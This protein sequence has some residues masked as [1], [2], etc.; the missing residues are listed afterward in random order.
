ML[1]SFAGAWWI[2]CAADG[3][4]RELR[5]GSWPRLGLIPAVVLIEAPGRL[6]LTLKNPA[7]DE[8]QFG[9]TLFLINKG[10]HRAMLVVCAIVVLQVLW[11]IGLLS[12]QSYRKR[13]AAQH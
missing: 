8:A 3:K 12:L 6:L 9:R 4:G 7:V 10:I 1:C 13:T 5:S 11:E 2:C